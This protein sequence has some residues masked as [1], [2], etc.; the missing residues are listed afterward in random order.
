MEEGYAAKAQVFIVSQIGKAIDQPQCL[1]LRLEKR[2]R[3]E[4]FIRRVV[5]DSL[6][7][8]NQYCYKILGIPSI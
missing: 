7:D 4:Q 6:L 8:M 3:E 2:N 1:H 5:Q